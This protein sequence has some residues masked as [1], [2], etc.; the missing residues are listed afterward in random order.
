M[1]ITW[2]LI[3]GAIFILAGLGGFKSSVIGAI[4]CLIIG[5]W[6]LYSHFRPS[7][8]KQERQSTSEPHPQQESAQDERKIVHIPS[9][10]DGKSVRYKYNDVELF[11][12]D[13][14]KIRSMP[15]CG[16]AVE[17][18]FE[19]D[20]VYDNRAIKAVVNGEF[21][22]Y[23]HKGRLQDMIHDFKDAGLP[24]FSYV[25]SVGDH[26]R[27]YIAFYKNKMR[28]TDYKAYTLV[29]NKKEDMQDA[30]DCC[31]E[32][33]DVEYDYDYDKEKYLATSGGDIGYF[34]KSANEIL[35]EDPDAYVLEI[36][37]DENGVRSVKVAV[38]V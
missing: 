14:T 38:E 8:K 35:S 27:I 2:K 12:P 25:S 18:V 20:N 24:I 9:K 16:D 36:A 19:P 17:L 4:A 33:D 37:E 21:V 6:L 26:I 1:R 3:V 23:M 32:G 7:S 10:I 30:I 11:T 34:P 13:G 29:S 22:G 28:S 15:V 31:E 5:A